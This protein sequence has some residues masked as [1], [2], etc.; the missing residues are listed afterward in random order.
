VFTWRVALLLGCASCGFGHV[1]SSP[2][3]SLP[4]LH[5]ESPLLVALRADSEGSLVVRRSHIGSDSTGVPLA[6]VSVRVTAPDVGS[7]DVL[8]VTEW[9]PPVSNTD[10]LFLDGSTFAPLREAFASP[11]F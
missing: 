5:I 7:G 6:K 4:S 2:C 3:A 9:T 10:S 8:V 11:A 1:A